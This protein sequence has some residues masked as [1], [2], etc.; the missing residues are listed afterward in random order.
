M[1]QE[2]VW[3]PISTAPDDGTPVLV[4]HSDW[5]VMQVGIYYEETN[6]WQQPNGDLLQ[7]PLYWQ[8][9]PLPPHELSSGCP[10]GENRKAG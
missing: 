7:T 5:E 4:F 1:T 3:E 9:L 10:S 8:A 2:C 6:T